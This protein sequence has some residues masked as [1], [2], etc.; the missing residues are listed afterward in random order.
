MKNKN[1]YLGKI[2]KRRRQMMTLTLQNLAK[3]AS[4]SASHIGRIER[5]ERF[6]SATILQRIAKHLGYRESELFTFAGYLSTDS[7]SIVQ[8]GGITHTEGLDSY[9]ASVLASEPL[10]TQRA[11]V[12]LLAILKAI[13]GEAIGHDVELAATLKSK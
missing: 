5:G 6:P 11:V 2:L 1:N 12:G 9:V 10:T 7:T 8:D 13:S 4:V 3:A